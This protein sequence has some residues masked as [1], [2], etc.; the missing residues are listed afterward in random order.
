MEKRDS[1]AFAVLNAGG[2]RL[3]EQACG[4]V[5][6]TPACSTSLGLDFRELCT[7]VLH[8]V[9]DVGQLG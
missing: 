2:C 8:F 1:T 3:R 9:L 6:G 4:Q 5:E 7:V